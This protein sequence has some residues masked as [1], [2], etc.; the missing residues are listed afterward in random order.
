MKR[1]SIFEKHLS[2]NQRIQST[3]C[4]ITELS[5][6]WLLHVV[7]FILS[8]D[9]ETTQNAVI[10]S[11]SKSDIEAA[12]TSKVISNTAKLMPLIGSDKKFLQICGLNKTVEIANQSK[13]KHFVQNIN[14]KAQF[15]LIKP[16]DP[17]P[18]IP[19]QFQAAPKISVATQIS[20]QTFREHRK[21]VENDTNPICSVRVAAP[22][23]TDLL[24]INHANRSL[25]YREPVSTKDTAPTKNSNN[26]SNFIPLVPE[27]SRIYSQKPSTIQ[28][29][30]TTTDKI[31]VTFGTDTVL[32]PAITNWDTQKHTEHSTK[33]ILTNEQ[34]E[35]L[36]KKH[37]IANK[38]LGQTH[39]HGI[40]TQ[41]QQ[42]SGILVSKF[43]K[44]L[45][46]ICLNFV[47]VF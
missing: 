32:G 11:A 34:K 20:H 42:G 10:I 46:F 45:I 7:I 29:T 36:V 31:R 26:P 47:F 33:F 8:M 28:Q 27:L 23:A 12:I 6:N 37:S 44:Y 2:T 21:A 30:A 38:T 39:L 16:L 17:P 40:C 13:S 43:R 22:S 25:V 24:T 3:S 4:T 1:Q 14:S 18:K 15:R 35:L 19:I 9:M 41:L 5:A